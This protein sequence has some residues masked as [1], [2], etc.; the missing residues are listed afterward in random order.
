MAPS[1]TLQELRMITEVEIEIGRA[2]EFQYN[3][4]I[5]EQKYQHSPAGWNGWLSLTF[6]K[7]SES[8]CAI[9]ARLPAMPDD[10]KFKNILMSPI[11][12]Y[13]EHDAAKSWPV[14][15]MM[16]SFCAQLSGEIAFVMWLLNIGMNFENAFHRVKSMKNDEAKTKYIECVETLIGEPLSNDANLPNDNVVHEN[17]TLQA[18]TMPEKE[19]Y[20]CS[21][22]VLLEDKGKIFRIQFNRPEKKNALTHEIYQDITDEL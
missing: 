22:K 10:F 14:T 18:E 2:F 21:R 19:K 1:R 17:S 20:S 4:R 9:A 12:I 15:H 11:A 6:L 5:P 16:K 3:T 8:E 13:S 7:L